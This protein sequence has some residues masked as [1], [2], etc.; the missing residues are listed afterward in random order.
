VVRAV[1]GG[2]GASGTSLVDRL[3]AVGF[4]ACRGAARVGAGG[5]LGGRRVCASAGG[6]GRAPGR[7]CTT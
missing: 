1:V 5:A 6:G 2:P 7:E 4:V 3:R